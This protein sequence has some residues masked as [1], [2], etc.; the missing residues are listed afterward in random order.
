MVYRRF[1]QT[2]A[3]VFE[4]MVECDEVY[5]GD[6]IVC[7]VLVCPSTTKGEQ[8]LKVFAKKGFSK[9]T[10][11]WTVNDL[12]EIKKFF[13]QG[14]GFATTNEQEKAKSIR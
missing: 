13:H 8:K 12:N 14:I 7:Q 6:H 9:I 5:I 2:D 10:N 4:G 3:D 1:A 11:V